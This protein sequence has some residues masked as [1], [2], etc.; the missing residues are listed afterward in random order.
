MVTLAYIARICGAAP[1]G[2]NSIRFDKLEE[3]GKFRFDRII[4]FVSTDKSVFG[5]SQ[6][7][8]EL[9]INCVHT[10]LHYHTVDNK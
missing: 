1:S 8:A 9:S 5:L 4:N 2:R 7:K 3:L 10:L 6:W